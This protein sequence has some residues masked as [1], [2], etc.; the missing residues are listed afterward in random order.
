MK[1]RHYLDIVIVK[2]RLS[3][4]EDVFVAHCTSLGITS[5]GSTIEKATKNIKEA[6]DLYLEE[7]PEKLNEVEMDS[8][9]TF[10]FVEV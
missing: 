6:I 2:E 4:K 5:Q 1:G 8:P 10:S 3:T 9:P 7:F